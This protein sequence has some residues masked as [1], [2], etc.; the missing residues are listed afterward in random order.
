MNDAVGVLKQ[1]SFG[2]VCFCVGVFLWKILCDTWSMIFSVMMVK[3]PNVS[4]IQVSVNDAVGMP[5]QKDYDLFI[6]F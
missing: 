3:C 1:S 5:K 4:F 2:F 6:Y